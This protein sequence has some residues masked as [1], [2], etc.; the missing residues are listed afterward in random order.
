MGRSALA[1]KP[2][3]AKLRVPAQAGR[4]LFPRQQ[5]A[6]QRNV[7]AHLGHRGADVLPV[8][9][10]HGGAVA[11]A[12]PEP[13]AAAGQVVD[14]G[15]RLGH[16]GGGA[17]VNR[18]HRRGQGD[19]RREV[20]KS[21][22]GGERIAGRDVRAVDRVVSELVGRPGELAHGR[23]VAGRGDQHAY[24]HGSTSSP[25]RMRPP[26]EPTSGAGRVTSGHQG[27]QVLGMDERRRGR[28]TPVVQAAGAFDHGRL[29]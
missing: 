20:G 16:R 19:R 7:L 28:R 18:G 26:F 1:V 24:L 5:G 14:G 13:E 29:P 17:V 3:K 4:R 9:A 22:Q 2:L 27:G 21:G 25:K 8:P 10:A 23:D 6:D 12:E 11:G 15:G